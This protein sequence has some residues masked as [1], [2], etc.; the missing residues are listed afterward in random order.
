VIELRHLEI[1]TDGVTLHV[2][3]AGP[4]DG[5]PIL[6]SHGFPDFWYTWR[7]QIPVLAAAGYHVL[8]PD[9]RGYGD[10]DVPEAVGA[11]NIH[12]LTDDLLGVLDHFH[13][14]RAVFVGHDW[15]ALIVWAMARLHP[16]RTGAICAMSVPLFSPSI[17]PL[18]HFRAHGGTSHYV[19]Q[20]QELG[21]ENTL[22]AAADGDVRS[23]FRGMLTSRPDALP[24]V[25]GTARA[26]PSRAPLPRWL[27]E[28]DLAYYAAQFGRTGLFGGVSYYRNLDG[29]WRATRERPY[30]DMSMPILFMTGELDSV[31]RSPWNAVDGVPDGTDAV[32]AMR[33]VLP[34]LRG[35]VFVE[36]AAHWNQQERAD[37]TNRALLS[38][39]SEVSPT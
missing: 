8:C 13:L 34:D 5:P 17:P 6:L 28:E 20:L 35:A 7:H 25:D 4:P 30:T 9:Q 22:V 3:E 33:R 16:A 27:T 31:H 21:F 14:E 19:V 11:Y 2:V 37:E 10:S 23:F 32:D 39:V 24:S 15:G 26:K 1:E 29:Y 38:F 36:G 18:E 12:R